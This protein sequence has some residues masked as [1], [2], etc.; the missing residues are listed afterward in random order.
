MKND[1]HQQKNKTLNSTCTLFLY[2]QHKLATLQFEH[3][4]MKQSYIYNTNEHGYLFL[5]V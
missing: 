1:K 5:V 3:T 2:K 4:T